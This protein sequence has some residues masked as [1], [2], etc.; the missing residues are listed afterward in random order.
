VRMGI[1]RECG[2][3]YRRVKLVSLCLVATAKY[4]CDFD[5]LLTEGDSVLLLGFVSPT[6]SFHLRIPKSCISIAVIDQCI[7]LM[8]WLGKRK[9][10]RTS[11]VRD[12]FD[13]SLRR[14]FPPDETHSK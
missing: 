4:T 13:P 5:S 1:I 12:L 7:N 9:Q 3:R 8:S 10:V 11:R 14:D 2:V 6:S